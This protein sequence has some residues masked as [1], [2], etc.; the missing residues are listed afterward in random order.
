M[1]GDEAQAFLA[2]E[3]PHRGRAEGMQKAYR[4]HPLLLK[5]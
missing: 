4:F 3:K 1:G 2:E 5:L